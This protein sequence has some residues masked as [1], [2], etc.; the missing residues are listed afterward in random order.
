[1]AMKF[2]PGH[3][4]LTGNLLGYSQGSNNT[5]MQVV[6][7]S[8][9]LI[10]Y[11]AQYTWQDF[12][13][14]VQG[15]YTGF[16]NSAMFDFSALQ[17]I[18]PGS[19]FGIFIWGTLYR[20]MTTLNRSTLTAGGLLPT[21]IRKCGGSL[22]STD[23]TIGSN[24][25]PA[26]PG[27]NEYGWWMSQYT[28]GGTAA[29]NAYAVQ[30]GA[31][32]W[33]P[34]VNQCYL[35]MYQ[36]I[37]NIIVPT[38][39]V[40]GTTYSGYTV[41]THPLIELI[42]T[43]DEW[44]T[45]LSGGSGFLSGP[46]VDTANN[47]NWGAT[48]LANINCI[49]SSLAGAAQAFKHTTVMSCLS[50][51][52]TGTDGQSTVAEAEDL[53]SYLANA[54]VAMCNSD[55]RGNSWAPNWKAS[56]C[57]N[58]YVGNQ[59][60]CTSVSFFSTSLQNPPGG[61]NDLRG[62][63]PFVAQFQGTDYW[64]GLPSG[65]SKNT[66]AVITN[67]YNAASYAGANWLLWSLVDSSAILPGQWN[68]Y[69]YP[70]IQL[71]GGANTTLPSIY[72]A[73]NTGTGGTTPA[74]APL[75]SPGSGTYATAQTISIS[76]STGGAS[77]YYTSNGAN[78]S[79]T[80]GT[81]YT[82]NIVVNSNITIKAIA[83][84]SGYTNSS[85]SSASYTITGMTGNTGNGNT[86]GSFNANVIANLRSG[87]INVKYQAN[88][89]NYLSIPVPTENINVTVIAAN[90]SLSYIISTANGNTTV[91]IPEVTITYTLNTVSNT[92]TDTVVSVSNTLNTYSIT[93]PLVNLGS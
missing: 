7:N 3:Y 89:A 52:I 8:P 82:T 15:D 34:V 47:N 54:R 9:R 83:Y 71:C 59:Y 84:A 77:I 41:D 63:M 93:I 14:T 50:Y 51:G 88:S 35:N 18:A 65:V 68:A 62:K 22:K 17:K 25:I 24:Q 60:A 67:Q 12:E 30:V 91:V 33:H 75:I 81:L 44:S 87:F 64:A 39:V 23:G 73:Y 66:T 49:K 74:A 45:D 43:D 58:L 72:A 2:N 85:I 56:G 32:L 78:P 11:V 19:R 80:L 90:N 26:C 92:L 1:M 5:E 48:K 16:M 21:Y 61:G 37:A 86:S 40:N 57:Q 10:G 70:G 38:V 27:G 31:H 29:T 20:S 6:A 55:L 69:I 4:G 42:G 28:A 46:A 53:I 76:D 79:N 13:D 36:A